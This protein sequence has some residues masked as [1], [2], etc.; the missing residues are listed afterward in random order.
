MGTITQAEI[1]RKYGYTQAQVSKALLEAEVKAVG[2]TKS[3][4]TLDKAV[5][6]K[7]Y[8]EQDAMRA[9]IALHIGRKR[10]HMKKAA[11]EA[12]KAARIGAIFRGEEE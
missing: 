12:K 11:E 9:L 2:L 5:H 6:T 8:D 3:K 7:L 4:N 1:A 10:E